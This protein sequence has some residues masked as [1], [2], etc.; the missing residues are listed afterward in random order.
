LNNAKKRE[1]SRLFVG[2]GDVHAAID[3]AIAIGIHKEPNA[4][5]RR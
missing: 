4:G 1:V 3:T 2:L 5:V